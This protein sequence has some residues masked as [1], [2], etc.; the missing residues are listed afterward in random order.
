MKQHIVRTENNIHN[1]NETNNIFDINNPGIQINGQADSITEFVNNMRLEQEWLPYG[2][3]LRI[4]FRN[5]NSKNMTAF[6]YKIGETF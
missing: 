1:F 4:I 3:I 5:D 2:Y 6:L